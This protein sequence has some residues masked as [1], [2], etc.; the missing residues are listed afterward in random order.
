MT[1]FTH[2]DR[3]RRP[4]TVGF[5]LIELMIVVVI[6]A[7][8]A[9]VAFP[10]YLGSIRKSRRSDAVS[11]LTAIQQAQE[12]WRA[13]NPLYSASLAAPPTGLGFGTTTPSGYY[14]IGIEPSVDG[15]NYVLT[16]TA[17]AGTSQAN[18][19]NCQTLR[20]QLSGGT[21]A[22]GGCTSCAAPTPPALVSDPD[23]CW[24]R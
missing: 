5:T 15:A 13:N 22:Y 24:V 3:S 21:V 18:D 16:A 9:A 12:R 10:A 17:R 11:Y 2:T 20:L 19:T 7:L 8:L 1:P 4:R 6:A 23:R 14:D